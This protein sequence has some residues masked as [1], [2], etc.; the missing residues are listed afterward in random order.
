LPPPPTKERIMDNLEKIEAWLKRNLRY[1]GNGYGIID[2][3]SLHE[4]I[5]TLKSEKPHGSEC[6]CENCIGIPAQPDKGEM[7]WEVILKMDRDD[8]DLTQAIMEVE[9]KHKET[10]E[11]D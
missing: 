5:Q 7:A 2:Y 9:A 6:S 8:C 10:Y 11:R 1:G 3:D 4:Y